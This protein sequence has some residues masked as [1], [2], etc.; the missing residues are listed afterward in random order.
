MALYEYYQTAASGPVIVWMM[1]IF[2]LVAA[3]MFYLILKLKGLSR[4]GAFGWSAIV[5][6]ALMLG[7]EIIMRLYPWAE[8][9]ADKQGFALFMLSALISGPLIAAVIGYTAIR[10]RKLLR[11]ST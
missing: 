4:S 3:V 5:W 6:L 1:L 2:S 10:I 9:F 8:A 7:N 11:E